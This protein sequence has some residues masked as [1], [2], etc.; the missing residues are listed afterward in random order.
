[1]FFIGSPDTPVRPHPVV[2]GEWLAS[3]RW[4]EGVRRTRLT[5]GGPAVAPARVTTGIMTGQWCPPPPATGQFLD[6]S[7]DDALSATFDSEPLAEPVELFGEP[8]VRLRLRHPGPRTLVSVKL[9]NVAPDGS[10]QPVTTAAVNLEVAGEAALELPLMAAGWRF[11]AG[12]RIRVAVA[13]ERLAQPV[14]AAGR[15]RRSRSSPRWSWSC[16][17]CRPTRWRSSPPTSPVVEIAQP[18]AEVTGRTRWDVV[19]DVLTGRAGHRDLDARPRGDP[20]RGLVGDRVGQPLGDGR[21]RR[22]A[23]RDASGATGATT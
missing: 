18:G 23:H 17:A 8:V 12:H 16:P 13:V 1:M 4:P 7:R 21:G 22:S 3:E 5:L 20:G 9:H 14:A 2:S 10:S 15:S 11:A 19:T 6:Q